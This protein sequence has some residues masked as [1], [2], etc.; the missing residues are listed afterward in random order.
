MKK[1]RDMTEKR[2]PTNI[3]EEHKSTRGRV[4]NTDKGDDVPEKYKQYILSLR[5]N[6][7]GVS[8]RSI[9]LNY[10]ERTQLMTEGE[11]LNEKI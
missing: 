8:P 10:N 3:G 9:H 6:R 7:N 1:N 4:K 2:N 11:R 5:K